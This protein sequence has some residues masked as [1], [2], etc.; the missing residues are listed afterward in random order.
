M[1]DPDHH[2][3]ILVV[4]DDYM[5]AHDLQRELEKLGVL[6]IGPVSSVGLA[7][8]LLDAMPVLDGAILDI[9]LRG[10]KSYPVADVLRERAIPFVFTSGY[11][12]SLVLSAYQDVPRL[13]KPANPQTVVQAILALSG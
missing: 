4:E 1:S 10:E 12:G 5:L 11:E 7:L 2:R 13:E 8:R 3:R 6:V 9:E